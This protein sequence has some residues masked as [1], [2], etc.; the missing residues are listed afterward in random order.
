MMGGYASGARRS[1]AENSQ[2]A[3]PERRSLSAHQAAKPQA[4]IRYA[5]TRFAGFERAD[6]SAF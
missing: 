1:L 3:Q 4:N 2:D 5:A 6:K